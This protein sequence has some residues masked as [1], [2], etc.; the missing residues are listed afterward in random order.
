MRDLVLAHR[1][2]WAAD[3]GPWAWAPGM[4][5]TAALAARAA[6]LQPRSFLLLP[7]L[8]VAAATVVVMLPLLAW[9]PLLGLQAGVLLPPWGSPLRRQRCWCWPHLSP[10]CPGLVALPG[11]SS[12][13]PGPGTTRWPAHEHKARAGPFYSAMCADPT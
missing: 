1:L 5:C 2:A 10:C 6:D 3:P 11:A 12:L 9:V 13:P 8:P 7:L 4:A